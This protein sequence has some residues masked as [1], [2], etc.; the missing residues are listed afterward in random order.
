[1]GKNKQLSTMKSWWQRGVAKGENRANPFAINF[2]I[3]IVWLVGIFPGWCKNGRFGLRFA[4][5]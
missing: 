3:I 4:R 2:Q 5:E 1:M